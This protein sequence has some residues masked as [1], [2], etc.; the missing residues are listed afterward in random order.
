MFAF[1]LPLPEFEFALQCNLL[2]EFEFA[3]QYNLLPE[4][5][6]VPQY[7]ETGEAPHASHPSVSCS[8]GRCHAA[9]NQYEVIY[10]FSRKIVF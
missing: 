2:P 10:C 4:F 8:A 6:F 3:L 7:A 1:T 9:A 5:E